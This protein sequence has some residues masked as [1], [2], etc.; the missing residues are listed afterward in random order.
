MAFPSWMDIPAQA[1]GHLGPQ[2]SVFTRVGTTLG[3]SSR[4]DR[5]P[6]G[7]RALVLD[8]NTRHGLVSIRALSRRGISVTAGSTRRLSAGAA[9]RHSDRGLRYPS[10][11]TETDAFLATVE[12]ELRA[13]D[14]DLLLPVH[15]ATVVP[16]TA[17]RQRLSRVT[18]VP[19]QAADDLRAALDKG[20]TIEVARNAGIPHPTTLA[21]ADLDLAA[22]ESQVGYPVVVKP[23]RGSQRLGV[24]ICETPAELTLAVEETRRRHGDVLL[25]EYIPNGGEFGVYTVYDWDSRLRGLTV[26]RRVRSNPPEGGPSTLRETVREPGLVRLADDILSA[27]DWQGAAMVEFRVDARTGQPQLMEINP[28]LW[29]SLAL[30]VAAGVDVPWLLF[31]LA[32]DGECEIRTNYEVGVRSC[33]LFGDLLQASAR[34]DAGTAVRELLA[35]VPTADAYDVLSVSDPAPALVYGLSGLVNRI[36]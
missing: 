30:T 35:T 29:G 31:Q 36:R 27:V 4:V 33:W 34:S 11:T 26:Q 18:N 19:F 20:Q 21:P 28:R 9:S 7:T 22:V 23:R 3:A 5:P 15:D 10:P 6:E 12:R 16:V 17:H 24:T 8:A 32:T 25:Q 14:Y 2:E 13:R 1:P